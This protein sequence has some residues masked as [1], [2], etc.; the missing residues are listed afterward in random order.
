MVVPAAQTE[1]MQYLNDSIRS[2]TESG[3]MQRMVERY[4]AHYF[5]PFE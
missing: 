4:G 2:L 1:L 3:D 5:S